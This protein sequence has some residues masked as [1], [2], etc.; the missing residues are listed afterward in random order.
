MTSFLTF[1]M[2]NF[3]LLFI[4]LILLNDRK[5]HFKWWNVIRFLFPVHFSHLPHEVS[6]SCSNMIRKSHWQSLISSSPVPP[7]PFTC[8]T[9]RSLIT[10]DEMWLDSNFLSISLTYQM[11][12]SLMTLKE[13]WIHS[14]FLFISLT[15]NMAGRFITIQEVGQ[16][17]NILIISFT[18]MTGSLIK[19]MKL[20]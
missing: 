4:S 20:D 7:P 10:N 11:S 15:Y 9:T 18:C 13:I 16:D 3:H 17:A 12:G 8:Y 19:I 2:I 6:V 5:F 1:G 14:C